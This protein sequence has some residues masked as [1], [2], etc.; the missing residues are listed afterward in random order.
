MQRR[1]IVPPLERTSRPRG[2][3]LIIKKEADIAAFKTPNIRNIVL[4]GR[5]FTTV[6]S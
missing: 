3:Y 6:R 5:T 2:R 4:T 1:S